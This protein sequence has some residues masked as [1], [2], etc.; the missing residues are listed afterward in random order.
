MLPPAQPGSPGRGSLYSLWLLAF[1][2]KESWEDGPWDWQPPCLYTPPPQC[3][4]GFLQWGS[5]GAHFPK[6]PHA[7]IP[8]NRKA[9]EPGSIKGAV[10]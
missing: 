9:P 8:G 7:E 5:S 2:I 1:S 4:P 10:G 6:A 3:L